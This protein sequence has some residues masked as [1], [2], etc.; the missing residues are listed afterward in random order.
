[1]RKSLAANALTLLILA[2]IGF[3]AVI[4]WGRAQ[5]YAPGPLV[6]PAFIE[7]IQG[8]TL[9]EITPR[10]LEAGI[11]DNAR[12]FRLG[13]R[14]TGLGAQ[15]KF[16]EYEI[17]AAASMQDVLTILASGRSVQ[18][19]VTIAEGLTSY[20]VVQLLLAND[21]LTGEVAEIPPEGSLAPE[22]YLFGRGATRASIIA[23]MTKAQSKILADAW[24]LRATDLPIDTPE[25]LLILASIIEKETGKPDERGLVAGVFVNRLRR[26]MRLQTDPSVIY[27][28]TLGREVLGRGLRRSE[29]RADTPYNTY[30]IPGL[31]P[32]PIANPGKASIEAAA[33]PEPTDYI[34]FVAD[35]TGGH[36]F[37]VT[38]A[39][40]NANVAKWRAAGN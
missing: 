22:T 20:E 29:L 36:A 31:P 6:K 24:A 26:N 39:E 35:G 14:Y 25:E 10:L 19:K 38:L 17:P 13:A 33:N 11:I 32:T 3:G 5:F 40:H 15:L 30:V 8:D 37:A 1:M 27:G 9:G 18:Y 7:V 21:I 23:Q 4:G 16:G 34:F 12:I 2:L 28:I